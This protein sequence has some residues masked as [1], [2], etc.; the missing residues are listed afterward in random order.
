MELQEIIIDEFSSKLYIKDGLITFDD[1]TI[2][3]VEQIENLR[4]VKYLW[5]HALECS[6]W[7]VNIRNNAALEQLIALGVEVVPYDQSP[8]IHRGDQSSNLKFVSKM[9]TEH[10]IRTYYKSKLGKNGVAPESEDDFFINCQSLF[11][12]GLKVLLVELA[13]GESPT[14]ISIDR[15]GLFSKAESQGYKCFDI[16]VSN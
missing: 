7:G 4:L 12:S 13:S 16:R 2:D 3:L 15:I 6:H 8:Q 11:N 10:E 14:T 1:E 5:G 9:N